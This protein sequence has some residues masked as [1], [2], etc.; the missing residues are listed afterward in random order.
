MGK[1]VKTFLTSVLTD[2]KDNISIG[3]FCILLFSVVFSFSMVYALCLGKKMPV[4][5]YEMGSILLAL[6]GAKKIPQ[7]W[8]NRNQNNEQPKNIGY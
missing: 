6:Y 2:G 1:N 4:T 8:E 3:S 5:G 7:I